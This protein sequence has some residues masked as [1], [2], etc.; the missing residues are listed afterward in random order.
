[1][2][3]ALR[4]AAALLFLVCFRTCAGAEDY[5]RQFLSQSGTNYSGA[6]YSGG[7]GEPIDA[8]FLVDA[9][10]TAPKL[11]KSKLT[12]LTLRP[13]VALANIRLGM[14]MEQVVAAWGRPRQ[15][16]LYNHGAAI[17]SY[18]DAREYGDA[19]ATADVLFRPGS[20]S[21]MAIWVAFRWER[22]KPLLSPDVDECIRVLGQPAARGYIPDPLEPRKQAPKHW[23][24]RMVYREPPLLLYF[25]DGRLMALEVNPQAKGVAPEGQGSDDYSIGFC[26]E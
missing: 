4:C 15:V 2:K 26:L 23:Y 11:A 21:V 10:N 5:Y 9:T 20:N 7:R 25:A 17:L 8:P 3:R 22:G 16:G 18:V 24:C 14:T 1:M 19:Y 12:E 6:L 13:Q